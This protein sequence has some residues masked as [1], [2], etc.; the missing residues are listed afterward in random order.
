MVQFVLPD[1][2][3]RVKLSNYATAE[4]IVNIKRKSAKPKK[5]AGQVT[6]QA[7]GTLVFP[8]RLEPTH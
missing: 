1:K 7:A 8:F 2:C 3:P 5:I 6:Q 4:V